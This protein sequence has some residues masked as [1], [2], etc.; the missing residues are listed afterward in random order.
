M[1]VGVDVD[2]VIVGAG[3][4]G[5]AAAI[6]LHKK[7][8]PFVV[9]EARNRIG[10]RVCTDRETFSPYPVDL[11]ASWIHL[12]GP[13]NPMYSFYQQLKHTKLV[14][15]YN[16]ND[17]E[18]EDENDLEHQSKTICAQLFAYMEKFASSNGQQQDQSIESV[19]KLEYERLVGSQR[20][21]KRLVDNYFADIEV[22]EASDFNNLSAVQ[23]ETVDT[24]SISD[25]W[26]S[27][28][29]GTILDDIVKQHKLSIRLNTLVKHIDIRNSDRIVINT[30]LDD[31]PIV[32]RRVLITIPLGCLKKETITFEPPLPEWKR[33][34]IA[35]MGFG[36]LNKIV[37]QFS[38][39]FWDP[40]KRYILR[41][42]N[43]PRSRFHYVVCLPPPSNILILFVSGN[44]AC[45]LETLTDSE[46]IQLATCFLQRIFPE[47]FVPN[48]IKYKITR[49][50]KDS[51]SFG[52][53]S[54][55]AVGTNEN[56]IELLA[57][58]TANDR[59]HW[60]GEHT[61]IDDKT[62]QW[63]MGCVQSA[64]QSGQRA[65]L[66]IQNQLRSCSNTQNNFE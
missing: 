54:N 46:T 7:S 1:S 28:G 48:V 4:A 24:S 58:T 34:A 5:I 2:V 19:M 42:C 29:Y 14:D 15:L 65:A 22:Y 57:R 37:L 3:A 41:T 25:K 50:F 56:T 13:K 20:E 43:E 62:D 44:D 26:V 51:L 17:D 35:Q 32:C 12:Y 49:W 27:F 36:V 30:A 6:E 45:A 47:S 23:W 38:D 16:D 55:Y 39:C 59:I 31:Y 53:Y 33:N 60:A 8:V 9:L 52:S 18:D 61:N 64:F 63:T 66:S 11:G 21:I 40:T 10:G